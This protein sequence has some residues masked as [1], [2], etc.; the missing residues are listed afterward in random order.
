M[1]THAVASRLVELI[2]QRQF[3]EAQRELFAPQVINQEP[4]H[5][6]AASVI[7]L[8]ALLAKETR[9]LGQ[10][11]QWHQCTASEPLVTA[12]HFSLRMTTEVTLRE[13]GRILI[14]EICVYQVKEGKIIHEQFFY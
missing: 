13:R 8:E 12:H 5:S 9:F 2:R 10:V 11:Q 3:L 14:D 1:D 7:G 4:T 6:M